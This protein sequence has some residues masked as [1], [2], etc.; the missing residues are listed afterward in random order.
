MIDYLLIGGI[1]TLYLELNPSM[2]NIWIRND[3]FSPRGLLDVIIFPFKN[4]RMWYPDMWDI[5]LPIW[6]II[7]TSL[8]W[9]L[10]AFSNT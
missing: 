10:K 8:K 6:V 5:N 2:G 1:F 3:H 9:L 4:A 7:Y